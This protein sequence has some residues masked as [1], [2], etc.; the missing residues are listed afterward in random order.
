MA[1]SY[2]TEDRSA[3]VPLSRRIVFVT[4]GMDDAIFLEHV[5]LG[6]G[7]NQTDIEIRYIKGLGNLPTYIAGLVKDPAFTRGRVDRICVIIDADDN[8][9]AAQLRLSK[10]LSDAGLPAPAAGSQ[11][12]EDNLIVG[13][14]I[15]PKIGINGMLENLILDSIPQDERTIAA[16]TAINE[17]SKNTALDKFGKRA[18]QIF[19]AL[20]VGELCRGPGQAIRNGAIPF[21]HANFPELGEFLDVFLSV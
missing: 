1:F 10:A 3:S 6:R 5:L 18:I 21:D 20:S 16:A 12:A 9:A 13:C 15:L 2:I 7:E 4:E 17:I 8:F 14:Y 19:L 11:I